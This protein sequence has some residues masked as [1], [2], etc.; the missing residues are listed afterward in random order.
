MEIVNIDP[1]VEGEELEALIRIYYYFIITFFN[2]QDKLTS[3]TVRTFKIP[4]I[5]GTSIVNK[6]IPSPG[7]I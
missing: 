6:T 2:P 1:N 5:E 4:L 7:E 3:T